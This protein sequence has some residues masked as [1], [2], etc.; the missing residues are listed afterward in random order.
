MKVAFV[1]TAVLLLAADE[2]QGVNWTFEDAKVGQLPE[3]WSEAKTGEGPGSV[4]KVVT[5]KT[6]PK[7]PNVL[8]QTCSDGPNSLFNLCVLDE[9]THA[10]VDITVSFK[11]VAGEI[12]QGGGPVWRYQNAD[13]YYICRHNPLED[14]F[15]IY[16]VIDGKRTQLA[17]AES[18]AAVGK[19]H[20][21]QVAMRGDKIVCSINGQKLDAR[22]DTIT[23][24]G[25]VGLWTKADAVTHFDNF[26]VQSADK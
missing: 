4:W 14:N 18:N 20:T 17:T 2:P 13:H 25:K 9:V 7:G 11:A 8:A 15:R 23:K 16:K 26:H 22:D 12:D 6:A 5:D 10:D 21:I 24:T 19:W 1:L 3:G